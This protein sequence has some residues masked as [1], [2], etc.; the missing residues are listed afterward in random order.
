M[1]R[2]SAA[3]RRDGRIIG[4]VC[5]PH[6]MSHAYYIALPPMFP[7]LVAAFGVTYLEVGVV[8][9]CFAL[10]A[11]V[12]QTPIGFV[13][14]RIGAR[15]VLIAGIALEAGGIAL[16]GIADHYWQLILFGTIAGFGH[17]VF[18]PADYAILSSQVGKERLGRAFALHSASGHAGF[19][20]SPIFMT[21]VAA[22]WHWRAAF[23]LIG[24]IGLA[25]ALVLALRP[26]LLRPAR[27]ADPDGQREAATGERPRRTG[28]GDGVGLLLSVPVLMCFLYFLLYQM[29]FGGIRNFLVAGLGELYGT[30]EVAAAAA[31]SAYMLGG[32]VGILSGGFVADRFG[33]QIWTALGTLVPAGLLIAAIGTFELRFPL[34]VGVLTLAGFLIGLLIPSRDLLLRSV[35]PD[36]SM[37]KVMGFASTGS[38]LGGALVPIL[39]GFV[40]DRLGAHAIFWVCACF[41][42]CAFATFVTVR[43]RF[44][45]DR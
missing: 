20:L 11:G 24:A 12:G 4:L 35:T 5:L 9:S 44:A 30:P 10:A 23:L 14:D 40:M 39:L 3:V 31:L 27:A 45:A 6:M 25:L 41:I 1:I 21:A 2:L 22:F 26:A 8:M 13:V 36:G 17:T 34:L 7:M 38:N 37:G 29:G 28:P 16:M 15:P 42:A 32:I 33:P 18:H 43:A 19:A